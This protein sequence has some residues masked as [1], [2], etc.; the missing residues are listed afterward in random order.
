[1]LSSE[2]LPQLQEN[3][4]PLLHGRRWGEYL[5]SALIHFCYFSVLAKEVLGKFLLSP[6][7]PWNFADISTALYGVFITTASRRQI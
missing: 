7:L 3:A 1:M 2:E 6:I 5:F 4:L